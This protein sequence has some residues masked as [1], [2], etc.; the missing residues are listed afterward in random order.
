MFNLFQPIAEIAYHLVLAISVIVGGLLA[1]R[2]Y[3]IRRSFSAKIEISAESKV[4][5]TSTGRILSIE[6][7]NRNIGISRTLPE[8]IKVDI[9]S[10][11]ITDGNILINLI[12]S[13]DVPVTHVGLEPSG[14]F[15]DH[16]EAMFRIVT[17][18]IPGDV[19]AVKISI[20]IKYDTEEYFAFREFS[21][22]TPRDKATISGES[23]RQ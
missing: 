23:Q 21:F 12:K 19:E 11:C 16:G 22:A 10:L 2:E 14:M 15:M 1:I 8:F 5:N 4:I 18:P 9:Y 20:T 6:L 3:R 7:T 13:I 17:I